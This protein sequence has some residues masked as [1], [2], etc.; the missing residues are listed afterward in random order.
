[1]AIQSYS[2]SYLNYVAEN[3]GVMLEHAVDIGLKYKIVWNTFVN[4]NVAKQIEK[5]NPK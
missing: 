2:Y 4:S 5:G 3:L 1:M